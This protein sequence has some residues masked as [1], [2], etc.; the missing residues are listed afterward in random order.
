MN[1]HS[2][3]K[4][5]WTEQGLLARLVFLLRAMMGLFLL[6][7]VSPCQNDEKCKAS[8][9]FNILVPARSQMLMSIKQEY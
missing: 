5:M 9:R 7:E 6:Q 2:D 8:S 3:S 4:G 1:A